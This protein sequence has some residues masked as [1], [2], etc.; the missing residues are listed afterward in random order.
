MRPRYTALITMTDVLTLTSVTNSFSALKVTNDMSFSVPKGQALGIIGPNGGGKSTQFNLIP[1]NV[2]PDAGTI[3]ILDR[4][5]TCTSA[6]VRVRMGVSR[7]HGT[8][9]SGGEQQMVAIGPALMS[10]PKLFLCDEIRLALAPVVSGEA[11]QVVCFGE[12]T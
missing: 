9:L 1:G 4:N 6:M 7:S 8:A 2:L 12:P 3:T 10:N 11:I 5:V